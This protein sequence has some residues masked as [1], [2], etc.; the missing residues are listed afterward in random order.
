MCGLIGTVPP[1]S[2]D[3][4]LN[5][6]EKISHR[7]PDGKGM[8]TDSKNITLGHVR[9]SI[10]DL[11]E[12]GNQPM[13][14]NSG[15][16]AIVFNGEIYNFIEIRTELEEKGVTFT[17]N[18]DTEV[19][20]AAFRH[21]GDECQKKFNGMWA[22]AIWDTIEKKLFLSRDRFGEKPLFYIELLNGSFM[23]ASEMKALMP[24]ISNVEA[25]RLIV[26][27]PSKIFHYES[28]DECVIKGI[29]R[30]PA[31]HCGWF[32][33]GKLKIN[34]WW[35]TLDNLVDAPTNYDDQVDEFHNLFMDACRL[36]MRSDVAIG[37]ALSGGLDSSSTISMMAHIAKNCGTQRIG[38][39]WKNA[40][41]ASFPGTP[42]DESY[43]AKMVTDHL[44][45]DIS[46]IEIDPLREMENLDR[47]LYLFEDLYITSPIPFMQTYRAV[48]ESGVSVTLDGH[49][50]DE[51]FAGYAFDYLG[52]LSETTKFSEIQN[53]IN[54]Y[55]DSL[56][57]KSNQ[58]KQLP[59]KMQFYLAYQAR[60]MA[61]MTLGKS[62]K[63]KSKDSSHPRWDML[64]KMNQQ[65]YVSTHESILPTLLRN[66]DRYS[67][68]NGVE[69]RMPFM[70]HRL[71]TF[72]FSIPWQSKIK[73]GYSKAIIRSA[74]AK[75]LPSEITWRKNKIGFNT[76]IV[77]WMRGPLKTYF[78]DLISD[79]A[80]KESTIINPIKVAEAVKY[81]IESKNP[82]FKDGEKAWTVLMPYLWERAF[83]KTNSIN[84]IKKV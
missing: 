13:F 65:L 18:S 61:K 50:A 11:S 52:A 62:L 8:W 78:M 49:G 43:Y 68:S 73:N 6:L 21:W 58:F 64:G 59:S 84:K 42:L 67:M 48:K 34:R 22:F 72:G 74:M 79:N 29:K 82:S 9:L 19:I 51:I 69:I 3:L 20:L 5:A 28:T 45:I 70:D 71:V 35:C 47:Y 27:D 66:Y 26:M 41:F 81:V 32:Q 37:T 80:F 17:T 31:G 40:F 23:F 38:R 57:R 56:P 54:T 12:S 63:I 15:R 7:G 46:K 39:N 36:R 2:N 16:Y 25:N 53:I 33:S 44:Q 76:P 24:F 14:D 60:R 75:Y 83:L 30:F 4:F 10:L 77:D 55:Y 1:I